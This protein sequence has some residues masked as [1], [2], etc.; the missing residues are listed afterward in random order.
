MSLWPRP[1]KRSQ[2]SIER[3]ITRFKLNSLKG[4]VSMFLL[5]TLLSVALAACS[6]GSNNNSAT[7]TP[8]ASNVAANK[9]NV[10]VTLV[11]FAVTKAAHEAIIPKFV[12]KWKQEHNQTVTFKQSYG[13]SGS[14][15]RAVIDGLEAD[16]VHLALAADTQKIEKAGLI[17]AGWE[18]EVPNDGIVSKSVAALVTRPDNPKGIQTWADLAQDGVKLITADPKTSGVA[19]WNFLALWNSVIKTG[20]DDAKALDFVTKVYNN[21]PILTKDAR[22]ATDA[23][24]KQGQGDVL[25]NYENEIVLAEQKG[26]K[27]TSIIPD[28]NISIDNP[29]AVVDKNVDKHGNREV[30]EAFAKYLYTPEA[31]QEF[32]KLGFRPVDE[33]V[34]NTKEVADKFPKVKTLGTVK[35]FGGWDAINKKFFADGAVFDQIQAKNKR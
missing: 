11:S 29:V 33:T 6:G 14:Q 5:G 10:E 34:A 12:E 8:A 30:A 19:R 31:Q 3:I 18:K 13:G 26:E 2:L 15:T 7:E 22:E 25:I 28:V 23:F 1:R 16:V 9:Q 35:D 32:A 4:F 20:G 21:V 24:F 17:Q 27:V